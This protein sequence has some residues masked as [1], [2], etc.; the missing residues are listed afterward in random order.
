MPLYSVPPY[1]NQQSQI[2]PST[3]PQ[4]VISATNSRLEYKKRRSQTGRIHA[5][6][7]DKPDTVAQILGLPDD[8]GVAKKTKEELRA[9]RQKLKQQEKEAWAETTKN[10]I[11]RRMRTNQRPLFVLKNLHNV[12]GPAGSA[13]GIAAPVAA[14]EAL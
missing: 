12:T 5:K 8:K 6:D 2:A 11:S 9:M 4:I 13:I 7:I 14:P 10:V 3:A 1:T